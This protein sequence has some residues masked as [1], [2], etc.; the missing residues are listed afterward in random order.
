MNITEIKSAADLRKVQQ[1]NDDYY[2]GKFR[3]SEA[4]PLDMQVAKSIVNLLEKG[5][6]WINETPNGNWRRVDLCP[7]AHKKYGTNYLYIDDD[8]KLM[9]VRETASEFYNH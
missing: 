9:R 6:S 3:G 4:T 7:G 2:A 8:N 5:Y 1:Y